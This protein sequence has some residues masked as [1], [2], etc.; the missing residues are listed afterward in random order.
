MAVMSLVTLSMV[1]MPVARGSASVQPADDVIVASAGAVRVSR[2]ELLAVIRDERSSGD[3]LRL[4][5]ASTVDGVEKLSRRLLEQK[6]MA[7]GARAAAL[8]RDP[9]VARLLSR[10]TDQLLADALV[11]QELSRVDMS[12]AAL[13]R[14]YAG[15]TERFRSTPRR[16]ARHIVVATR[17]E[18]DAAL[19]AVR[20]GRDFSDV[21]RERNTDATKSSGG[22]LGW[23]SPGLMVK[24]FDAALFALDPSRISE[25]VQTSFGWHLIKVD[26][27]DQGALPPFEL[28]VER[29]ATSLKSDVVE[30]MKARLFTGLTVNVDRQALGALVQ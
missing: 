28:I 23:V 2:D 9:A 20:G 19:A 8:D 15:N 30:Q 27:V 1:A 25:P 29:V 10:A 4:A 21:A 5:A 14:Y 18:A 22:E 24:S 7:E 6:V 12:E 3:L 17:Q 11:Q 26:Q 16:R 13:R